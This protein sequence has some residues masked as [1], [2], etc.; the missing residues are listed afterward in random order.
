MHGSTTKPWV[1]GEMGD[2]FPHRLLDWGFRYPLSSQ[3]QHSDLE[4][5]L[6]GLFIFP[7]SFLQWEWDSGVGT[8]GKRWHPPEGSPGGHFSLQPRT[9]VPL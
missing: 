7:G 8:A 4:G 5:R 6:Q 1:Q 3:G 2:R 9:A